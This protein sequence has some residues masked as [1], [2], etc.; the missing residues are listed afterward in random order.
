ML[1]LI[2]GH[3]SESNNDPEITGIFFKL[4]KGLWCP[5]D[6]CKT[7]KECLAFTIMYSSGA[8]IILGQY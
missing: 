6:Y 3:F 8:C 4:T 5:S 2:L 1:I 7:G